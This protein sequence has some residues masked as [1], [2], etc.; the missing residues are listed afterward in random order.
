MFGISWPELLL[1]GVVAI[2]VIGPKDLPPLLRQAGKLAR[3]GRA[4]WEEMRSH[5]DDLTA[6]AELAEMQEQADKLQKQVNAPYMGD[7]ETPEA[8]P[9]GADDK[10]VGS[11]R[12]GGV[13]YD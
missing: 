2:I 5:F 1:I 11:T 4:M 6:E 9:M 13:S 12:G 10:P 3:Q 7:A 8:E